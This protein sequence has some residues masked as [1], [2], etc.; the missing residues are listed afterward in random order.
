MLRQFADLIV[1]SDVP[2]TDLPVASGAPSIVVRRGR[3]AHEPRHAIQ[4][5][6]DDAGTDWLSIERGDAGYRL[7]M[8]G[9]VCGI[10]VTGRN[11]IVEGQP[12]TSEA[13]LVHL[14]LHQVLPLA[15][16]RTGRVVLHACAVETPAGAVG[17]LGESGT[18][19]STLAAA[20]SRRGCALVADDA[21][22]VD[23]AGD[24]IGVWPTADGLRLWDDMGVL[25][26]A[27]R[28]GPRDGRKLHA[29]VP[30]AAG[31]SALKRLYL[32]STPES[33][34]I[35]IEPVPPPAL[36]VAALSHV[37]RLDVTDA[38]E[39]RRLFDAAQ[40]I[41]E[42]VPAAMIAYPPGVEFLDRVVD[43][44]FQDLA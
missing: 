39:S 12:E 36:R 23:L 42:R 17:F 25:A 34:R 28:R 44:I 7:G 16:S 10:D 18:G 21:L 40:N 8:P 1:D 31:R 20:C 11:V 3:V 22:V 4:T 41:A 26:D 27:G 5:W 30:I 38:T 32:L 9:L 19:K 15:V 2:F 43:A 33:G 6:Q 14:L 35:T 24:A 13:L 37:F 29:A